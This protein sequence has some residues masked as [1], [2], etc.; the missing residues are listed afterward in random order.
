MSWRASLYWMAAMFIART[1]SRWFEL[2]GESQPRATRTPRAS[3]S[4]IRPCAAAP[5]APLA[6]VT[7]HIVTAAPVRATQSTSPSSSPSAWAS[8]TL[9]PSTPSAS[10]YSVGFL[11]PR[12]WYSLRACGPLP[13]WRVSP[14]P[15]SSTT[16]L[17]PCSSS[18][19]QVSGENGI[20]HA[21][22]RP[23]R[24]PFHLSMN[25]AVR[26]TASAVP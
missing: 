17:S 3:S 24:R 19:L 6:A 15:R 12:P 9:G 13:W 2:F 7:G 16:R 5:R 25:A 21:R 22:N 18:A 23:S 1:R 11:A 8:T 4:G 20:A 26:V 14:V 10:R